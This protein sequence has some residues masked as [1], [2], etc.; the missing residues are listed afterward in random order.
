MKKQKVNRNIES[1]PTPTFEL[2]REVAVAIINEEIRRS[3]PDHGFYVDEHG[4][5]RRK[6]YKGG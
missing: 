5:I 2:T 3:G 6:G 4:Y 1:A